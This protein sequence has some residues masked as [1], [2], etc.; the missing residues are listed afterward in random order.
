MMM[1]YCRGVAL[2]IWRCIRFGHTTNSSSLLPTPPP[3]TGNPAESEYLIFNSELV[4][5]SFL[6]VAVLLQHSIV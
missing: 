4:I 3:E 6:V 5:N 1:K 2:N